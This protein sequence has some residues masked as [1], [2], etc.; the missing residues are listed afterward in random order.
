MTFPSME[1]GRRAVLVWTVARGESWK[2]LKA[3]KDIWV[4][5]CRDAACP[6][7]VRLSVIKGETKV[8]VL[9][10]HNCP[11][12]IHKNFRL[13][14]SR[15]LRA[16]NHSAAVVDNR[17]LPPQQI[18]SAERLQNGNQVSYEQACRTEEVTSRPADQPRL[19]LSDLRSSATVTDPEYHLAAPSLITFRHPG[20]QL[21]HDRLF[22]LA[23]FDTASGLH[24][25]TAHTVCAIIA[26]NAFDGYLTAT[27]DGP[28]LELEYDDLLTAREYWFHV[29]QPPL[30]RQAE[31]HNTSYYRYP[32]VAS[33]A[34]WR[35]PHEYFSG[36]PGDQCSRHYLENWG[37]AHSP[38]SMLTP[39]SRGVPTSAS[40][41]SRCVRSQGPICPISAA[42]DYLEL[43]HI[44]PASEDLWFS[45]NYMTRYSSRPDSYGLKDTDNLVALRPDIH[46]AY[47]D[48]RFAIVPKCGSSFVHFFQ[49][50]PFMAQEFHNRKTHSL[51]G[52]PIP[53]LLSRFA[54]AVIPMVSDFLNQGD[55]RKVVRLQLESG[56]YIEETLPGGKCIEAAQRLRSP[57]GQVQVPR[58]GL[59]SPNRRISRMGAMV[60]TTCR[61]TSGA[62]GLGWTIVLLLLDNCW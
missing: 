36:W 25:G 7:R 61:L 1:E 42:V 49:I 5:V 48:H 4:A 27:R 9:T 3:R 22:R 33:F 60:G 62:R 21:E 35:F 57:K 59:E 23:C 14:R 24:Y 50:N 18:Q 30:T 52:V 31:T 55:P 41:V 16:L 20:Y 37:P 45:R 29:S 13:A 15:R 54:L 44:I 43:A 39:T 32:I 10:M 8:T 12:S 19:S 26:N 38:P 46:K 2:V 56:T 58:S 28:R 40:Q 11:T 17:G 47:N 51:E 34:D 53:Y 6:F